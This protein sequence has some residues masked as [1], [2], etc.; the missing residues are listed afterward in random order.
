MEKCFHFWRYSDFCNWDNIDFVLSTMTDICKVCLKTVKISDMA[1]LCDHCGNWI[2]IKFN[3]LDKI[4]YEMIKSTADSW[5]CI[6][7]TS[8]ILSFCNNQGRAKETITMPTNLFHHNE[9]FHLIKNLNNLT[10]E[11]SNDDTISLNVSNKYRD[12]VYFCNLPGNIKSKSLS[13]YH[14]NV[15][16]LSKDFDQLHALL[17]E[18]AIDSEFIGITKSRISKTNFSPINI[19]LA[20]Y[21]TEQTPTES[22]AGETVL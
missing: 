20:N 15:C 2:H 14:H 9:L 21:A 13:I 11:S 1:I 10:E 5:S 6:T 22:N 12:P 18:L 16:S 4:H 3:N 7:C 17:K 8:N 19:A